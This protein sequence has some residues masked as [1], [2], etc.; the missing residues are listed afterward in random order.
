MHVRRRSHLRRSLQHHFCQRVAACRPCTQQRIS[1]NAQARQH[2]PAAGH[3]LRGRNASSPGSAA[4]LRPAPLLSVCAYVA[5]SHD[6]HASSACAACSPPACRTCACL[7]RRLWREPQA[8][9]LF[10]CH[11]PPACSSALL[12][13]LRAVLFREHA[14]QVQSQHMFHGRTGRHDGYIVSCR[15]ATNHVGKIFDTGL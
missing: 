10:P 6:G 9:V 3:G 15:L 12:L 14:S 2:P 13:S 8:A 5:L 1:T 4:P 7:S 11:V